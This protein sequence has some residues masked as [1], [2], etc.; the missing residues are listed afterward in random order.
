[1]VQKHIMIM[2]FWTVHFTS[3]SNKYGSVKQNN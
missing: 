1:M 3:I 2:H